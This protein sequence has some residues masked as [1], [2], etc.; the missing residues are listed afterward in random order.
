MKTKALLLS[1]VLL[2]CIACHNKQTKKKDNNVVSGPTYTNPLLPAGAEPWA[3]FHDGKY[4][5]TQGSENK[6]IIWETTD[7]TDLAHATRKE[8]WIPKEAV[9]SFHL[10]G[11]EIH[12]IDNKWYIY[13][14]ADDGNMDNHQIYVIENKSANPLKGE[15]VMKGRIQTDKDNNWAIHATTFKNKGKRYMIWCG[16]QKKR[17]GAE[18]QCI[19]I[20]QMKNPWTLSSDRVSISQ[21]KYE[22]ERQ[23][24]NPDGTKTAY[25]IHVNEAPQYFHSKNK[26]KILIYYS[27]SGSWTPYYCIGLLIANANS[28]LMIP[29]SWKKSPDPVFRQQPSNKVYGPGG[30]SFIPSPNG[31]EWY[32]LYHARKM[33]NDA[34]GAIDSRTP[35]LQEVKWDKNGI[36]ILGTPSSEGI[37]L[38]KPSGI[39]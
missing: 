3:V 19:Y 4:Y 32:F 26:D 16:W 13:F 39:N 31:K 28:D 22:W 35:R 27:A 33:P 24:I 8:M 2:L 7:I 10:W 12:F 37:Q 9:N 5:Y 18:N 30:L 6:I 34:P 29:A 25:P 1:A 14:A 17:I 15:F 23:W 11:P 21:P 36:P 38:K 20:A